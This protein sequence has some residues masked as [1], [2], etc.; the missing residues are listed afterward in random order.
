MKCPSVYR[1]L[2]VSNL[3]Q[4]TFSKISERVLALNA[5]FEGFGDL[6]VDALPLHES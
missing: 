3:L 2:L 4:S 5:S 1:V 6:H